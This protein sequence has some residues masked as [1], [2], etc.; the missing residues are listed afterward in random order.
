[1][2]KKQIEMI[3]I[4]SFCIIFK[5]VLIM[6]KSLLFLIPLLALSGCSLF[7]GDSSDVHKDEYEPITGKF[8]LYEAL[9]KRYTYTDT[10]FELDGSKGNFSLKYYENGSLKKEGKLARVVA[11]ENNVGTWSDNLHFNV[12]VK[13]GSNE[14]ICT[15]TESFDPLN[16]FRIIQE[17]DSR[18]QKYYLSETPYVLGTY[19]RE[20]ASYVQEAPNKNK[21]DYITP[22]L[23]NFTSALDGT[24][25]LD[26][27]HYFY[28]VSP[29]GWYTANGTF[30]DSY[31]QYYSSS[32]DK[33]IEGFAKGNTFDEGSVISFKTLKDSVDWGKG[34]E[35]RIVFGYYTFTE[36]DQMIDHFGSVDFSD[37]VVNS[38]TFEHLSRRWTDKEWDLYT[39][40]ESYH[41]PDA[42]LYDYIGGTYQRVND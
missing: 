26:D 37:G 31:F 32:L 28:F 18:D 41:L 35:G 9:D 16:Q 42:I 29:K 17:Y 15:Y 22:T 33:P 11:R 6:K 21:D 39:K 24:Y 1:M 27:D 34:T 19:V 2:I 10:Y 8:V 12:K 38:F 23:K 25:R 20:G 36:S 3:Y 7:E 14:H 4:I 5:G 13:N 30:L 40:D